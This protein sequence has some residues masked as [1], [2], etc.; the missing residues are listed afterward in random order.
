MSSMSQGDPDNRLLAALPKSDLR[1]LLGSCEIVELALAELLYSPWEPL[2]C[3]Y[4]PTSSFIS[5]LMPTSD[6]ATF[7]VGLVGNEGML[8]T[9]LALNTDISAE[10]ATVYGAGFALRMD[11]AALRRE[12]RRSGALRGE[13]E[14]YVHVRMGQ[15]AQAAVCAHFH[16]LEGRVARRLLMVQEHARANTF[17]I[18]QDTLAAKLGVRRAGVTRAASSLQ[19]RRLIH[20]ARGVITVLDRRGLMVASCSCY[21][22]DRDS[23]NRIVGYVPRE[24]RPGMR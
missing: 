5:L 24:S 16:L 17:N 3:V 12:L 19:Q 8:G 10:R 4:F 14:R 9:A 23:Q 6:S 21:K 22:A 18:T 20:Y 15:L 7:E 2:D 1:R 11:A 13:I